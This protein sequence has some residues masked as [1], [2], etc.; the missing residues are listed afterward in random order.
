MTQTRRRSNQDEYRILVVA[1]KY[2]TGFD[3][4]LL[5][6]DVRGQAADRGRRGAD[7]VPAQPDAPAEVAG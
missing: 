2:Q 3:Q 6:G 4:P 5:C 1:D 7:A